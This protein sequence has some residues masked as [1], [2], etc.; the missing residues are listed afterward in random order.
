MN[1]RIY[2]HLSMIGILLHL[3]GK[4]L[5]DKTLSIG[6]YREFDVLYMMCMFLQ[7]LNMSNIYQSILRMFHYQAHNNHLDIYIFH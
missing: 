3:I 7:M 6:Y 5:Q 4:I 1:Y 2:I